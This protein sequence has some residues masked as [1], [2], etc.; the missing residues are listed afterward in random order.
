MPFLEDLADE[1]NTDPLARGYSGMTD[2]QAADDLNIVNRANWVDLTSS[3]IFETISA[4][5]FQSLN[6]VGQGRV[7]RILGLGA[8]IKTAPG[9]QARN[10]LIAVFGG[11]SATITSLATVAN[12]QRSRADELGLGF[13]F[14]G[15]VANA[16]LI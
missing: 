8:D 3:Q 2:A 13:I 5:E 12:Q 11:G 4:S 15:H 9:S 6:Q 16:R 14:E 1:L 10:E 7:D